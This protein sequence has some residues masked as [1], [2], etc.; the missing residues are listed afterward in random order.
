ML[1]NDLKVPNAP[2]LL[3]TSGQRI[4]KSVGPSTSLKP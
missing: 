3:L 4:T 2:E 1:L